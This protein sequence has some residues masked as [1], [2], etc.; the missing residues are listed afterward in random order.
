LELEVHIHQRQAN[1]SPAERANPSFALSS[2]LW[3]ELFATEWQAI[4]E[5][6]DGPVRL[7]QKNKKGHNVYWDGFSFDAILTNCRT[8][9]DPC[10]GLPSSSPCRVSVHAR[11]I[12]VARQIFARLVLALYLPPPQAG[13]GFTASIIVEVLRP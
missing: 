11:R 6:F 5:H 2:D 9:H 13:G 8:S 7:G 4:V 10:E 12:F 3:K 1:L